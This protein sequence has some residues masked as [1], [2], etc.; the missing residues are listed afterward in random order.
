MPLREMEVRKAKAKDR[1]YRLTDGG[2]LHFW[3]KPTG[4]SSGNNATASQIVK[5]PFRMGHTRTWALQR[6]VANVWRQKTSWIKAST[7]AHRRSWI[8][9]IRNNPTEPPSTP[10]PKTIWKWP[11]N[12]NW[13]M[14]PF[15]RRFGTSKPWRHL[16]TSAPSQT[17]RPPK[18]SNCSNA[19][20]GPVVGRPQR[21]SVAPCPGCFV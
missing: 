15:T 7:P 21:N 5:R 8:A 14:R 1:A 9:S 3:S 19:S 16:C 6:P 4:Q 13:R 12:A 11:T 10:W 2:G 18:F 17:S 20:N